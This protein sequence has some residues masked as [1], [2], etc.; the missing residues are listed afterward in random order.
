M[1]STWSLWVESGHRGY[2]GSDR[3]P[4]LC[5]GS[6]AEG[7]PDL[8]ISLSNLGLGLYD[9]PEGHPDRSASLRNLGLTLCTRFQ[10]SG[11]IEDI[12]ESIE[13]HYSALALQPEGH[14]SRYAPL[15]DLGN[16][17]Y[18]RFQHSSNIEDI[19]ESIEFHRSLLA[20]GSDIHPRHFATL[21]K[22]QPGEFST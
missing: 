6:S 2:Y 7:H 9:Q 19:S 10:Q 1:F 17:L 20:L 11:Y 3:I 8:S 15:S 4:S 16:S 5:S 12:P 21:N 18:L 22:Q 14:P 13:L